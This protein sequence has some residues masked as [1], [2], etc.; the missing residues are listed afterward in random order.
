MK[1]KSTIK[2]KENMNIPEIKNFK[3]N[4]DV[5][6]KRKKVIDILYQAKDFG[7]S[8]P[9]INVRIGTATAKYKNVLGVGGM[10]NIWITEKAISKG[11]AYLLHVVL[12]ELCHA[13]YNLPHNENCELMSS[14]LGKPCNIT[15]AWEIFANY[16]K[17]KGGK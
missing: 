1:N 12:H 13:V 15:N 7:I 9:R 3:M 5:Y 11:Y 14:K 8:L 6:S 17:M 2:K 16:S 10:K 4:N